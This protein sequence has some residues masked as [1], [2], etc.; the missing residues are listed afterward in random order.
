MSHRQKTTYMRACRFMFIRVQ[1]CTGAANAA[2]RQL[3]RQVIGRARSQARAQYVHVHAIRVRVCALCVFTRVQVIGYNPR[4]NMYFDVCTCAHPFSR[5][6]TEL[7]FRESG[8]GGFHPVPWYKSIY[9]NQFV[10]RRLPRDWMESTQSLIPET[11][12]Q[13]VRGVYLHV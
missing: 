6:R 10:P 4:V 3:L 8:L 7:G 2:P 9:T 12:T 11:P 5:A 1:I 13:S